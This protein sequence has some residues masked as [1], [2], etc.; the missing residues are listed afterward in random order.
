MWPDAIRYIGGARIAIGWNDA[1]DAY[2]G[3][4]KVGRLKQ[5]FSDLHPPRIRSQASVDSP[6]QY[7]RMAAAAVSFLSYYT[8]GNRGYD[9]PDW[10]PPADFADALSDAVAGDMDDQGRYYVRRA[11]NSKKGRWW[12]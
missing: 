2:E 5:T 4:I 6:E 11:K 1:R 3:S 9:D 7:D 12:G 10:I 8:T